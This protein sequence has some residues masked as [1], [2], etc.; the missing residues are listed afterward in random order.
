MG[1]ADIIPGVSGGTVALVLGI[2]E[3]L[4]AA[5]SH[6]DRQLLR[7][8]ASRQWRSA[9]VHVDARFL[10][11]L[12]LG[13]AV[14]ILTLGTVIDY[15]LDNDFTRPLT[16]AAFFGM[17]GASAVIVARIISPE[18]TAQRLAYL[19]LGLVAAR[20]AWWLSTVQFAA[21]D[22][23]RAGFLFFCGMIA[24]CAMILPGISGA[25][26]LLILGVYTFVR[27]IIKRITHLEVSGGDLF[28]LIV[29][30]CGCA[31]GL[32]AFSKVLRW[33]LAK[34][35]FPTM[36]VLCGFMVGALRKVWPFQ[37]E[38][39]VEINGQTHPEYSPYLPSQFGGAEFLAVAVAVT[40]FAVVLIV[41]AVANKRRSEAQ[42]VE[43]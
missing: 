38:S 24:I 13:I 5:I 7:H 10:V 16:W 39:L 36:A 35:H 41:D 27:N 34:F 32:L 26:L 3:R 9:S 6:F 20:F 15:L 17:I 37:T 25:H 29:F 40:A 31:V 22:A 18:S 19:A 30:G 43:S 14:G 2:Y 33:L 8:L 4:V 28:S 1:A 21:A 42:A 11:V 12:A 23:P